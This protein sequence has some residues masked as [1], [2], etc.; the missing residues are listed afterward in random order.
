MSVQSWENFTKVFTHIWHSINCQLLI[1]KNTGKLAKN[2]C[3]ICS[4]FIFDCFILYNKWN[5]LLGK[6]W[7]P[8]SCNRLTLIDTAKWIQD[9]SILSSIRPKYDNWLFV[10]ICVFT[11]SYLFVPVVN[12]KLFWKSKQNNFG[13]STGKNR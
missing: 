8:N 4:N 11:H 6:D 12:L 10:D 2:W 1:N 3:V 13:F 5:L 9:W 7:W